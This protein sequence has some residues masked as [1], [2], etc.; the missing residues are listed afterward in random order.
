MM[1]N[2]LKN[3]CYQINL[4]A[5]RDWKETLE[6]KAREKAFEEHKNV[7][8]IALIRELIAKEYGLKISE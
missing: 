8:I 6:Q 5:P 2:W 4:L 3:N 7:S 1:N